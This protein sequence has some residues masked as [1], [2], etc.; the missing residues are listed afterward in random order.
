[1]S[2]RTVRRALGVA[3]LSALVLAACGGGDDTDPVATDDAGAAAAP[4][5][6]VAPADEAGNGADSP[7][8]T[9]TAPA[10]DTEPVTPSPL[11]V[12]DVHDLETGELVPLAAELPADRPVLVWFWAPH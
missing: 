10:D 8:S 11:P 6:T 5:T 12:V 7:P 9:T 2:P 3:V 4:T 1:M